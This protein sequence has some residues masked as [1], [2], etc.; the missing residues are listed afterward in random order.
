VMALGGYNGADEILTPEDLERMVA[1]REIRFVMIGGGAPRQNSNRQRRQRA[2]IEWIEQHGRPVEP[3]LWRAA[4][5]T[6]AVDQPRA[7]PSGRRGRP[8]DIAAPPQLFDLRPASG[9]LH[10]SSG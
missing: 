5:N 9:T 1:D 2:L 10:G 6:A 3:A 8:A 4:G 7:S